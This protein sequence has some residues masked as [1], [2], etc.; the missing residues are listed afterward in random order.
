MSAVVFGRR[1]MALVVSAAESMP[2]PAQMLGSGA[3]FCR[4]PN[5]IRT[6]IPKASDF[7]IAEGSLFGVAP[8]FVILSEAEGSLLVLMLLFARRGT[9]YR[10][11][12]RCLARRQPIRRSFCS[13]LYA[14]GISYR[15]GH[16]SRSALPDAKHR[17]GGQQLLF[18]G[19]IF[20][21]ILRSPER[22]GLLAAHV[23]GEIRSSTHL[24]G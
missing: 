9:I 19:G 14:S 10:A 17:E 7:Q 21:L 4:H 5:P 11:R 1:G 3:T 20:A 13:A 22:D 23:P 16:L 12:H 8:R 18:G 15:D 2:C 6:V 24:S